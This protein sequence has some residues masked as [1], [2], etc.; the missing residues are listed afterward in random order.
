M[1][2]IFYIL[3]EDKTEMIKTNH[4]GYVR[5]ENKNSKKSIVF[6]PGGPGITG[7]YLD[8]YIEKNFLNES[9]VSVYRLKLPNHENLYGSENGLSFELATE[10]LASRINNIQDELPINFVAHS[11]GAWLLLN[12]LKGK[13]IR[14][15]VDKII[16]VGMPTDIDFSKRFQ[17]IKKLINPT[18]I[19]ISDETFISYLSSISELYF[20]KN[21]NLHMQDFVTGYWQKN[22]DMGMNDPFF[23]EK[24]LSHQYFCE[25]ILLHGEFDTL[26]DHSKRFQTYANDIIKDSGHF[27][28]LEQP[29]ASSD[30]IKKYLS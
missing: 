30:S 22:K 17:D 3:P 27:P 13:L 14:K 19:P 8:E 9:E 25:L 28:M 26:I 23:L 24:I 1:F 16:L 5:Y 2:S 29:E 18:I 7:K 10:V 11:F 4:E 20:Y 15:S 6:I 21:C 12:M